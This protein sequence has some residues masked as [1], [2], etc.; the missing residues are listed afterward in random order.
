M[1]SQWNN[2]EKQI[3]ISQTLLQTVEV[4]CLLQLQLS[5]RNH[6]NV[7]FI[8]ATNFR[9]SKKLCKKKF[10]YPF[11]KSFM[12]HMF[13]VMKCLTQKNIFSLILSQVV[14]HLSGILGDLRSHV[15]QP[16]TL[17][18]KSFDAWDAYG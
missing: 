10:G 8:Y 11:Y 16:C 5:V 4:K 1:Y 13:S 14:Q 9:M 17:E 3:K 12:R 7:S 2:I 15:R 18:Q 6:F